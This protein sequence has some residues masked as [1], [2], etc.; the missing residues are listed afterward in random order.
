LFAVADDNV[1]EAVAV[2]DST[3]NP[4]DDVVDIDKSPDESKGAVCA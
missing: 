2:D 1:L 3:E 4:E